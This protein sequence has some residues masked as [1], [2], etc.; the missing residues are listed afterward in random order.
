LSDESKKLRI[1]NLDAV[2]FDF[3]GTLVDLNID[4]DRMRRDVEALLPRYGLS[5]EGNEHLYTLELIRQSM[6]SLMARDGESAAETFRQAAHTAI[7]AVELEAAAG[8]EIHAGVPE[9]MERLQQH[10]LKI[11]IVTRNCRAA[12]ERILGQN[13][14][15]HDVLVTRDDVDQVKPHPEH[16]TTALRC[17]GVPAERALMVGD[18]PMD[19]QAGRVIGTRT[20]AVLTGYSPRERFLPE[21]PDMILNEVGELRRHLFGEEIRDTA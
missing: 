14:L 11:G 16:L 3:D 17:L 4:F 21:Q 19:I 8:A 13:T 20:V 15:P 1:D 18:H 6:H 5:L 10:G 9:L 7:V 12:V 2:L